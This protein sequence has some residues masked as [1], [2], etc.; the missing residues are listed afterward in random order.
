[1]RIK[2]LKALKPY[3][4]IIKQ[5]NDNGPVTLGKCNYKSFGYNTARFPRFV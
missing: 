3:G 2:K 5:V 4:K 1:M